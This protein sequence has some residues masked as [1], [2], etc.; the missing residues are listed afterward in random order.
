[1][2]YSVGKDLTST[3]GGQ[4]V[5]TLPMLIAEDIVILTTE[6]PRGVPQVIA[7]V[8]SCYAAIVYI[9]SNQEIKDRIATGSSIYFFASSTPNI[10]DIER[11]I[12]NNA[13]GELPVT[14]STPKYKATA[15]TTSETSSDIPTETTS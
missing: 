5:S 8:N 14:S 13:Y 12:A 9:G 3:F 7:A 2:I 4:F 15:K 6:D 11:A 10:T 1:M